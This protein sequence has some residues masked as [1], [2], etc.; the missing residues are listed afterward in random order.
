MSSARAG[1]LVC[2]V[3]CCV[4]GTVPGAWQGMEVLSER[5]HAAAHAAWHPFS[6]ARVVLAAETK[7]MA[8]LDSLAKI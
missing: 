7:L 2:V 6:W 4:A 8:T 5:L 3:H 1:T